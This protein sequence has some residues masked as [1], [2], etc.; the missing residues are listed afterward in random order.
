MIDPQQ[1]IHLL[2]RI[3]IAAVLVMYQKVVHFL[4]FPGGLLSEAA[5][6]SSQCKDPNGGTDRHMVILRQVDAQGSNRHRPAV[7]S[8]AS[9]PPKAQCSLCAFRGANFIESGTCP[10]RF[11]HRLFFHIAHPRK[12][13]HQ[14]FGVRSDVRIIAFLNI[15]L[16]LPI[17]YPRGINKK[18]RSMHRNF[19]QHCVLRH[20]E[21]KALDERMF[22]SYT[23]VV[24]MLVVK[25]SFASYRRNSVGLQ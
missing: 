16:L 7:H 2:R 23:I 12:I 6:R 8:I 15:K 22:V 25:S 19:G 14:P 10:I 21:I 18:R 5:Y 20:T 24:A 17:K 1:C 13:N 9:A 11:F 4:D 3:L